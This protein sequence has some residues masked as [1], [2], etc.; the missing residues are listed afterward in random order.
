MSASSPKSKKEQLVTTTPSEATGKRQETAKNRRV[1]RQRSYERNRRQWMITKIVAGVLL[2]AVI[3][4]IAFEVVNKSSESSSTDI[5]EGVKS[6]TYAQGQHDDTFNAWTENPPVGGIHNNTWQQC[7][8][9]AA[10]I[11]TGMGVHSMEHGAVW[12]TYS[13]DLPQDEIDKLKA[14]AEGQDFILVSPYDGL[15]TPIVVTSWNHQM[16]LQTYDETKIDQFIKVFKN[17]KTY[18]PEFG[19]TCATGSTATI[20]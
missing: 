18:T 11:V 4:G 6:Y 16:Q 10:P 7:G 5:P 1:E 3:G 13:R 19:A 20:S 15:P 9:Y 12:I 2:V 8:Y 17:N 14:I